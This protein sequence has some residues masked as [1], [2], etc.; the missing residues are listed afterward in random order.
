MSR[1]CGYEL[2]LAPCIQDVIFASAEYVPRVG[3]YHA[4]MIKGQ[5]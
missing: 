1:S 4:A 3:P 2:N 5:R